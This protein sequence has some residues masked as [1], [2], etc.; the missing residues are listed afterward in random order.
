MELNIERICAGG[1]KPLAYGLDTPYGNS[2]MRVYLTTFIINKE[3][4]NTFY[5]LPNYNSSVSDALYKCHTY[6]ELEAWCNEHKD[7]IK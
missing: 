7:I 5:V 4:V 1:E 3:V 2:A 6:K